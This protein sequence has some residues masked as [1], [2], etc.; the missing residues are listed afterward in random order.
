MKNFTNNILRLFNDSSESNLEESD[1]S[2]VD[3][4]FNDDDSEDDVESDL[5]E[6]EFFSRHIEFLNTIDF[7]KIIAIYSSETVNDPFFLYIVLEKR[8]T[9]QHI[10]DDNDHHISCWY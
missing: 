3:E 4:F 6:N 5:E 1:D 8:H 10:S 9:E 7:G 2:G